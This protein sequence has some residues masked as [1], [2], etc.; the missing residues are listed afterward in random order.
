LIFSQTNSATG[1]NYLTNSFDA[2][3][4]AVR[5]AGTNG[6]TSGYNPVMDISKIAITA[7]LTVSNN[8]TLALPAAP[9]GLTANA[10]NLLVDLKW[11]AV[12]GATNYNL[13][14]GA[15]SAGP[16][17]TNFSVATT[18]YADAAVSNAVNYYY[19]VTAQAAGGESTNSSP[20]NAI[21][22]PSNQP[23]NITALVAG[24]QLQ[25]SWPQDHL[26]WRLL[27]Q[28]NNLATGLSTNWATVPNST[29]VMATN[30]PIVSTN[31]S[32]FLRLVYP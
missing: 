1:A 7:T 16:W 11:N 9:A 12:S 3:C 8:I 28:T 24:S 13:K 17:T 20:A 19:V 23:T 30:I 22:L 26:G 6:N 31:G 25:L 18:N 2:L 27:I 14:R 29:N 5:N 10:T 4:I 21:P 32:V 15:A